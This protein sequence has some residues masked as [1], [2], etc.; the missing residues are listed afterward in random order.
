MFYS[1]SELSQD[2]WLKPVFICNTNP[3][4]KINN[5][6]DNTLL[7]VHLLGHN[8]VSLNF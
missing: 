5:I 7:S 4:D 2:Q 1:L 3:N 8:F 6:E